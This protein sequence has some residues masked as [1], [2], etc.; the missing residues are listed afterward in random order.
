[1]IR[2]LILRCGPT[3]FRALRLLLAGK[4]AG[5]ISI[6]SLSEFA[7]RNSMALIP[8]T[9]SFMRTPMR[10]LNPVTLPRILGMS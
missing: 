2:R 8:I 10:N 7:Y 4:H 9:S 1:M 6:D 3:S 5:L